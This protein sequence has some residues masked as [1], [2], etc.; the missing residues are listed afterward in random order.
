VA[1]CECQRKRV[2]AVF[3]LRAELPRLLLGGDLPRQLA[4]KSVEMVLYYLVARF[5]AETPRVAV[6]PD[7]ALAIAV[8]L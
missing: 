7:T 1:G 2:S 6:A 3:R 5:R 4:G 8:L